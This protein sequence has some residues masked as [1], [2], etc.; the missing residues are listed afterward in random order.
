MPSPSRYPIYLHELCKLKKKKKGQL[1][2]GIIRVL[3]AEPV[4]RAQLGFDSQEC[5]HDICV[6]LIFLSPCVIVLLLYLVLS[7]HAGEMP[8]TNY[9]GCPVKKVSEYR[10]SK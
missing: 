8:A 7:V 2:G 10:C 6:C 1:W 4:N 9:F 3:Q 5:R